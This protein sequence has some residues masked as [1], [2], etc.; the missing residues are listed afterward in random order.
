VAFRQF[1]L[2]GALRGR[3]DLAVE[4]AFLIPELLPVPDDAPARPRATTATAAPARE[5]LTHEGQRALQQVLLG[6]ISDT[7]D[8]RR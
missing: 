5:S 3:W 1:E 4:R 6:V 8:L 7:Q 2:P